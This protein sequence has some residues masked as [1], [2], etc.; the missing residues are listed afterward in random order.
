MKKV[1]FGLFALSTV[2]MAAETNLYLRAGADLN[3]EYDVINYEGTKVNKDEADDFSWEI[4]V[5]ATREIYPKVELGL[6]L[7]YQKH[8]DAKSAFNHEVYGE[9]EWDDTTLEM[10]G[11]TS[12]P[13]YIVAKYN[14]DAINNFVPYIK[15]NLGYSFNDEDGDLKVHGTI[16]EP[17][18][19]NP[20]YIVTEEWG[21]KADVKIENG[22][23]YGIGAGFEYNNFTM[24]LMY[25]VNEA[26]AEITLPENEK[27]KKDYDYSRVTLSFGY[28]F[29]F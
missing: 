14:F 11:Y 8:G 4:A 12:I 18:E 3:G 13:L 26:E 17:L 27:F 2:A 15:A 21:G 28:K 6:G 20:D 10:A 23:Y 25:Q 19:N 29:N 22:L 16:N 24:D 9:N 1:L 5:E 7:A